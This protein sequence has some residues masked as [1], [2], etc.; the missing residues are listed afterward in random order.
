MNRKEIILLLTGTFFL[1]L[2]IFSIATTAIGLIPFLFSKKLI[3]YIGIFLI[4]SAFSFAILTFSLFEGREERIKKGLRIFIKSVCVVL[5]IIFAFTGIVLTLFL[6]NSLI[7][8]SVSPD[9][10]YELY[11]EDDDLFGGWDVTVYK[12]RFPSFKTYVNSD[13]V[14][15]MYDSNGEIKVEWE[16]DGCRLI[17]EYLEGYETQEEENSFKIYFDSGK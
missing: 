5:S 6:N 8:R 7:K 4:I 3:D 9:K 2:I 14:E 17:Y 1:L 11:I 16:D 13:Y 12:R 10:K 15:K